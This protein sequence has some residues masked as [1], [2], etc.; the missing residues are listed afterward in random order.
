MRR[1]VHPAT[2]AFLATLA[3]TASLLL[4]AS[5]SYGQNPLRPAEKKA[6]GQASPG[7]EGSLPT[8]EEVLWQ[9]RYR[10]G[11]V[12]DPGELREKRAEVDKAL[13]QL[14]SWKEAFGKTVFSYAPLI[15]SENGKLRSGSLSKE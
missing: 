4:P 8:T 6:D 9:D 5:S 11:Q 3:V 2:L 12:E 1:P 15:E 14:G 7:V 10:L 13:K